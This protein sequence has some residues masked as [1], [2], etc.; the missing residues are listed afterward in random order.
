MYKRQGQDIAA[1]L[2]RD[3]A[4]A[5]AAAQDDADAEKGHGR[6]IISERASLGGMGLEGQPEDAVDQRRGGQPGFRRLVEHVACLLYT[7]RCV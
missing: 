6:G 7:S 5:G 2:Q 3:L 4:F 1:A